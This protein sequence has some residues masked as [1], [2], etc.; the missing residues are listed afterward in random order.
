MRWLSWRRGAAGVGTMLIVALLPAG[1]AVATFPGP[2]GK[3]LF[4]REVS[5]TD[6]E[7]FSIDP[8]GTHEQ[9][10]TNNSAKDGQTFLPGL[11]NPVLS[12]GPSVSADGT[13]VAFTSTRSG[14]R[15]VWVMGIDGSNPTQLTTDA[16]DDYQPAFSP[17]GMHV[18]FVSTRGGGTANLWEMDPDGSNQTELPNSSNLFQPSAYPEIVDEIFGVTAATPPATSGNLESYYVAHGS[19]SSGVYG[20][21]TNSGDD[22]MIS[23]RPTDLDSLFTSVRDG[24]AEVYEDYA[25]GLDPTPSR[26][27]TSAQN[28]W[29]PV[30]SPDGHS[31]LWVAGTTLGTYEIYGGLTSDGRLTN[32]SVDDTA[33][34][35]AP[36]LIA[37]DTTIDS[38][39]SG[40]TQDSTPVFAFSA[41]DSDVTFTCSISPPGSDGTCSGPGNTH[42]PASPLADGTY[43]FS[44]FAIDEAGNFDQTPATS[45]FTVDTTPPTATIAKHPKPVLKTRNKR[46]KV[47]F[48]FSSSE[49]GSTFSCL[50]DSKAAKHCTSPASYKVSRGKHNFSVSARDAA[51]NAGAKARFAFK[52]IRKR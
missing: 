30:P 18:V 29:D 48:G 38:G 35:W 26:F 44:V 2:P 34:E 4:V 15:D 14:N 52:V 33:P 10:L 39:A 13:K 23:F 36:D 9:N 31:Y 6:S 1:P 46:V 41:D 47:S 27:T 32:N 40:P 43:T 24:N 22:A 19:G 37:P 11:A 51:G 3:I 5:A 7:I 25:L 42:R 12:D 16:A 21:I 49:H 45:T 50:I 20:S 17:D 8:D 28:E